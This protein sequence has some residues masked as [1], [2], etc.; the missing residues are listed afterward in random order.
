MTESWDRKS[1]LKKLYHRID[2]RII[3]LLTKNTTVP[4]IRPMASSPIVLPKTASVDEMI[5]AARAY[6]TRQFFVAKADRK[7]LKE[8]YKPGFLLKGYVATRDR[9]IKVVKKVYKLRYK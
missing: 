9:S 1:Q 2:K 5:A 7:Q 3:G 8:Q 4:S 6:D